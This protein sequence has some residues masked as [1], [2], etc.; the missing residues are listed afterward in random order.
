[1]VG[2]DFKVFIRIC[3]MAHVKT[4]PL[5]AE[6]N[7]KIEL[8]PQ[9]PLSVEDARRIVT[10]YVEHHNTVRLHSSIGCVTPRDGLDGRHEAIFGYVTPRDG[11]DGRHEAIFGY[12]APRDGLE[13]RHEA[14]FADRDNKLAV[15]REQRKARQAAREGDLAKGVAD[16]YTCV[17]PLIS[18]ANRNVLIRLNY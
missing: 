8:H 4:A 9:T 13:G 17:A 14:I 15:A 5:Y 16:Y 12:V 18:T 1:L 10:R 11:L 6:S 7:G 3:G 2:R